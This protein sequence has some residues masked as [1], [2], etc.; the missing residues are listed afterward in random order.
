ML[1]DIFGYDKYLEITSEYAIP[2]SLATSPRS[3]PASLARTD[4]SFTSTANRFPYPF[5][6][7]PPPGTAGVVSFFF[8]FF[9]NAISSLLSLT[10]YSHS[11]RDVSTYFRLKG[12]TVL[13]GR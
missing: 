13:V 10:L 1:S 4:N 5:R 9:Q 6:F 11:L 7:A 3:M 12:G 2:T 8:C